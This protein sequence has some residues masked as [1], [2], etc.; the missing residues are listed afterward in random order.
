MSPG[1]IGRFSWRRSLQI[2]PLRRE[3]QSKG[4]NRLVAGQTAQ[5][6]ID[7]CTAIFSDWN[8]LQA[9]LN[10]QNSRLP[11]L[12]SRYQQLLAQMVIFTRRD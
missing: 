10:A 1:A 8:R 6:T 7:R 2:E 11:H 9:D 12:R 3:Y 4:C 5:S